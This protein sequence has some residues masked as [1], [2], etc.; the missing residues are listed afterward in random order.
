MMIQTFMS[1]TQQ[2]L[3]QADNRKNELL[4]QWQKDNQLNQEEILIAVLAE[5][6]LIKL[7]QDTAFS[8]DKTQDQKFKILIEIIKNPQ[9]NDFLKLVPAIE[10]LY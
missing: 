4:L 6:P 5:A 7:L 2:T 8:F 9:H 1:T 10:K 3:R